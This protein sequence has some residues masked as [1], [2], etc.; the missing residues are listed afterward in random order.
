MK[1]ETL[2]ERVGAVVRS[3]Y[4]DADTGVAPGAAVIWTRGPYSATL[5]RDTSEP[6]SCAVLLTSNGRSQPRMV[7]LD[8]EDGSVNQDAV[9]MMVADL[10]CEHLKQHDAPS[11]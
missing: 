10:V 8:R 7:V 2:V 9:V 11:E 1:F 3:Q 4:P 6:P 5:S